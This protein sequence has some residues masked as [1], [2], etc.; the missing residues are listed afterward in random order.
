MLP[1]GHEIS[2]EEIAKLAPSL[3]DKIARN[4]ALSTVAEV[5]DERS[6]RWCKTAS[7][8]ERVQ[9]PATLRLAQNDRSLRA[10]G[11]ISR[12]HGRSCGTEEHTDTSGF[13]VKAH[14]RN[15][16]E[17]CMGS[18]RNLSSSATHGATVDAERSDIS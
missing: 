10:V 17:L 9:H 15:L 14:A 2:R 1:I 7:V 8:R 13:Y 3:V 5:T 16:Q 6:R 12:P 11:L 4:T 18:S